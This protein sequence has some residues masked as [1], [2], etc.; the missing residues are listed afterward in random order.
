[1]NVKEPLLTGLSKYSQTI[2]PPSTQRGPMLK[3][4]L[5]SQSPGCSAKLE[6]TSMWGLSGGGGLATLTKAQPN[7]PK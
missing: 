3:Y 5:K 7:P 4:Q 1:V 2:K 6:L